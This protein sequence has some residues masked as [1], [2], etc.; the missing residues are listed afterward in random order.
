MNKIIKKAPVFESAEV[1]KA[2]E[3]QIKRE[4][5]KAMQRVKSEIEAMLKAAKK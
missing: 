2:K 4:N 3:D 5:V 1:I